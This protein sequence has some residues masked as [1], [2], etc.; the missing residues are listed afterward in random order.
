MAAKENGEDNF[1]TPRPSKIMKRVMESSTPA[2]GAKSPSAIHIPATPFLT[3]LGFGTGVNVYLY[4]R[5]PKAGKT[6]SPWAVKKVNKRHEN[7][8]FAA[9][10]E[11]EANLL[12]N[13]RHPNIIGYRGFTKSAETG[14]KNLLMEDG[15][16]SLND[17]MEKRKEELDL[18]FPAENIE[19]VI[20]GVCEALH[21]IHTEKFIM[22]GD[23]KSANVLVSQDFSIVKL[24]DFGVTLQVDTNGGQKNEDDQYIG[25]DA[26]SPIEAIRKQPVTTK[27]DIFAF[28]L[29]IYEMLALQPPHIDKLGVDD[30]MDDSMNDSME[31]ESFDD[32]AYQA[33]LGSRPALPDDKDLDNTYKKTLEIFFSAT[34]EDPKSRPSAKQILEIL[35]VVESGDDSIMCVNIV[36]ANAD[37][38]ESST[39]TIDISS[40]DDQSDDDNDVTENLGD[41]DAEVDVTVDLTE[42]PAAS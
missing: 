5:S 10:L 33:A 40:S 18:P 24:C 29:V 37:I 3:K 34:M 17:M 36:E 13:L 41:S 23:L 1:I 8:E 26:W 35:E 6:V 31:D 39:Q 7:T 20:K 30:S 12:R 4:E 22:H 28:G 42:S 16:Q 38:Q 11:K 21:Y 15:H 19:K 25:T 14:P 9:R 27:A 2:A 32:S